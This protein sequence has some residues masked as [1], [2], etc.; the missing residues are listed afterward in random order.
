MNTEKL[1]IEFQEWVGKEMWEG[2]ID[3]LKESPGSIAKAFLA[4]NPEWT[5]KKS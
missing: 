5:E 2:R 4:E 3:V 1:L